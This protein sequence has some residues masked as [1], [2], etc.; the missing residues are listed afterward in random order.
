MTAKG[1]KEWFIV[2]THSKFEENVREALQHR[3]RAYELEEQFGEILI[4]TEKVVE[5][6]G[7]RRVVTTKQ[8]YPGYVLVNMEMNP[9]TWQVVKNTDKVMGF[10]PPHKPQPMP[11]DEVERIREQMAE[12]GQAPKLRHKFRAGESVRIIHGPF[13]GFHGEVDEVDQARS[14]LKVMVT[15][16][17]RSTPV[18]LEFLEVEKI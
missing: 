17:G 9:D 13:N 12:G 5:M 3:V 7:G 6:R 11:L 2:S 10:V 16:F 1:A 14:R 8:V 15:I 4:P 18:E